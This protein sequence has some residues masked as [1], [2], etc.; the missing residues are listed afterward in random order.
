MYEDGEIHDFFRLGQVAH[1]LVDR[2][3]DDEVRARCS[4]GVQAGSA[5]GARVGPE[6]YEAS[7]R[8]TRVRGAGTSCVIGI[9][10]RS[11]QK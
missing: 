1:S 5:G 10:T 4:D 3:A 7:E 2:M 9:A 6:R 8:A 11:R